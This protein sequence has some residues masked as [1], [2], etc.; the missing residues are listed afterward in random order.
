MSKLVQLLETVYSPDAKIDREAGVVR[1]VKVLGRTSAN[2]HEYTDDALNDAVRLYEGAPVNIDHPDRQD[3]LRERS[4]METFGE[5]RDP[6]KRADGVYGDLHFKKSHPAAPVFMESAER[7]PKMVGLSHNADGRKVTRGRKA[8][9]E[10]IGRVVG[11]DIV[12]RPAT[13]AG[14]FES[15]EQTV[16]KTLKE[17][18]ESE[19]P[20]TFAGCGLLEMDGMGAMPVDV[21]A[22]G[23]GEDQIWAAFKQAINVAVDDDKLDIK[24]TLKKVGEI[25]KAYEKLTG[26]SD[27]APPKS[28]GGDVPT[29]ESKQMIAALTESVNLL[30][31][32]DLARGVMLDLGVSNNAALLESL[33]KQPD[34]KAMRELCEKE[35]TKLPARSKPLIE[36]RMSEAAFAAPTPPTDSKGFAAL[37][38]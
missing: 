22:E 21:P 13:N 11:V 16:P 24:A 20:K 7:F 33:V 9:I 14:L 36:S 26:A 18:I 15:K 35:G 5:I 32:R 37:V 8:F 19:Y 12:T 3:R 30:L 1:G 6:Q 27:S 34:E 28:G 10:S 17:I 4:F 29:T 2:G 23:S 25:L 38:R 31:K